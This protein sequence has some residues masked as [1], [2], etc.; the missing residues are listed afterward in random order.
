MK[1]TFI[2]LR[3]VNIILRSG[4]FMP[5]AAMLLWSNSTNA[6]VTPDS[7]LNTTVSQS[8]NNFTIINGNQI[9]KNLFHSFSQFSLPTNGSAFFDNATDIQNIFARVT[10]GS[11]SNIDG[12]R[13]TGE[14]TAQMPESSEVLV[15]ATSWHRN[16]QGK[17]EL[18]AAQ[19][20]HLQ[21]YLT[22]GATN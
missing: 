22:C 8:G 5:L 16:T 20:T 9:G 1:T 4:M 21:P 14:L 18:I 6:Q 10:G 3:L 11:V 13:K 2:W 7:T 15:Q 19:P 12:F 17:I